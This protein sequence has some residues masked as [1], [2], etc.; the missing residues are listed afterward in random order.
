MCAMH[1]WDQLLVELVENSRISHSPW[2]EKM[3][4]PNFHWI[5]C[6]YVKM[7]RKLTWCLMTGKVELLSISLAE[8]TQVIILVLT[9]GSSALVVDLCFYTSRSWI[10]FYLLDGCDL[11]SSNHTIYMSLLAIDWC[12]NGLTEI[13]QNVTISWKK[14]SIASLWILKFHSPWKNFIMYEGQFVFLKETN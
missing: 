2:G 9:N 1:Y 5:S 13:I 6:S 11:T 12:L 8:D 3:E 7:H 4:Q 14:C 10:L